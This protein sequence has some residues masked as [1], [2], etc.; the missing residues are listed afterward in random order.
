MILTIKQKT[1]KGKVYDKGLIYACMY[2]IQTSFLLV[3]NTEKTFDYFLSLTIY[4]IDHKIAVKALLKLRFDFC[5]S[6]SKSLI[7]GP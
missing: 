6:S 3:Y 5:V 4:E 2:R 1:K 7:N